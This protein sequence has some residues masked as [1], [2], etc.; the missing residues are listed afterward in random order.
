MSNYTKEII[1]KNN[2]ET[3]IVKPGEN[4]SLAQYRASLSD[5]EKSKPLIEL[6]D[7][8]IYQYII[9]LLEFQL[10]AVPDFFDCVSKT[11]ILFVHLLARQDISKF[12]IDF[13]FKGTTEN[14]KHEHFSYVFNEIDLLKERA[15]ILNVDENVDFDVNSDDT[16]EENILKFDVFFN[17]KDVVLD[18]FRKVKAQITD[19][20]GNESA[21]AASGFLLFSEYLS[22]RNIG[23]HNTRLE[24]LINGEKELNK[25]FE[26]KAIRDVEKYKLTVPVSSTSKK[27]I[28]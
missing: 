13:T 25:S 12:E 6:G 11:Q 21:L 4:N 9:A 16:I 20:K 23:T 15:K 14:V 22:I 2:Y 3:K 28:N 18:I 26:V 7:D 27:F 1:H 10:E 19:E 5:E 17:Q 8:R 24:N